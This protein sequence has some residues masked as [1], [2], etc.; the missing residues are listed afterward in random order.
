MLQHQHCKIQLVHYK[1]Y[2]VR[3]TPRAFQEHLTYFIQVSLTQLFSYLHTKK[4]KEHGS[5]QTANI[6]PLFH[7]Y[8]TLVL[9]HLKHFDNFLDA[10]HFFVRVF[11]VLV[12]RFIP[13]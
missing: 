9:L 10:H 7:C 2:Q 6:E 8:V 13:Y 5:S 11:F 4:K 3:P 12:L 1:V